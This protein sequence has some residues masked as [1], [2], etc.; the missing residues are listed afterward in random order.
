MFHL[1]RALDSLANVRLKCFSS[2][3]WYNIYLLNCPLTG[4]RTQ[5]N[6]EVC[7][8]WRNPTN[9][10]Y[11][12]EKNIYFIFF[13]VMKCKPQS[14][15]HPWALRGRRSEEALLSASCF[16][17]SPSTLNCV[18]WKSILWGKDFY[19]GNF[20]SILRPNLIQFEIRIV[21][22]SGLHKMVIAR[23]LISD[24]IFKEWIW[25]VCM[26]FALYCLCW[27][28]R[29]PLPQILCSTWENARK[30][31]FSLRLIGIAAFGNIRILIVL[32]NLEIK[33]VDVVR[34]LLHASEN[35]F[36]M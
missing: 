36:S 7:S 21:T 18:F 3:W 26:H 10:F 30:Y 11:V 17:Q 23:G 22:H 28:Y 20:H 31:W 8:T 5:V 13:S 27:I 16:Q 19:H 25:T 14:C 2:V 15:Q 35:V 24:Q 29:A 9:R 4:K 34:P 1:F 12:S 33:T 6:Q 32:I